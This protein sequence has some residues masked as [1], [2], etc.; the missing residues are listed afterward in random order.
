M[1]SGAN[2]GRT[3]KQNMFADSFVSLL[4]LLLLSTICWQFR[5]G[6]ETEDLRFLSALAFVAVATAFVVAVVLV[7]A[8]VVAV[9]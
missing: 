3:T 2:L 1:F 7:A 4:L 8:A 6:E 9:I 5:F